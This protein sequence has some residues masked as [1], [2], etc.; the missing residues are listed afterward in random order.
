MNNRE[1]DVRAWPGRR[2]VLGS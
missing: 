2:R 1:L